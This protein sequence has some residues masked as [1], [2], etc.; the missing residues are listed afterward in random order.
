MA[1]K[2]RNDQHAPAIRMVPE[3]AEGRRMGIKEV[4]QVSREAAREEK[5]M[6]GKIARL[7]MVVATVLVAGTL[8]L[9]LMA[10]NAQDKTLPDKGQAKTTAKAHKSAKAPKLPEGKINLNTATAEQLDALPR[11]G[12]KVAQR[13][14]DY[15]SEHKSFKSIDELRNVK[16]VGAKVLEAIRPYLTL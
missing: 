4:L 15:R 5:R 9:G 10:R 14:V 11:I 3:R 8:S 2:V 6:K 7:F 16:G 13:I 12:P 1:R